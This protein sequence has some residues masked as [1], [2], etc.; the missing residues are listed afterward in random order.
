MSTSGVTT[1]AVQAYFCYQCNRTVTL[2]PSPD[3]DLSCPN[4]NGGFLE[5]FESS[6]FDPPNPNRNPSPFSSSSMAFPDPLSLFAD[7]FLSSSF[8]EG[9]GR[10]SMVLSSTT[11]GLGNPGNSTSLYGPSAATDYHE[12]PVGF[13]AIDFLQNYLQNLRASGANVQFV[14]ENHPP[15]AGFQLPA[16]LG[17]Y[18]LGPG[19]EQLI[20][21]LAENDPNRYGT[22]PASKRSVQGLP[23]VMITEAL[24]KSDS[25][26]CAVCMNEFGVGMEVKQ[27]PCSHLYH[28]DCLL[29]WLE[30]H[31]SCP[32]C[33]YELP[34]DDPDY[35]NRRGNRDQGSSVGGLGNGGDQGGSQGNP[36]AER[37]FRIS[38]PWPLSSFPFTGGNDDGGAG[39]TADSSSGAKWKSW[40][41]NEARKLGL[42]LEKV[43]KVIDPTFGVDQLFVPLKPFL[44][45]VVK[46]WD[47]W[48]TS[49][50]FF[51][52][53]FGLFPDPMFQ[54]ISCARQVFCSRGADVQFKFW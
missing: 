42:K 45:L 25:N 31:N 48:F 52:E 13:N 8:G 19:L 50:Y 53:M 12:S 3:S 36:T 34:T 20:Q 6:S 32:V 11:I 17:D 10:G 40:F 46:Q 54:A 21:Q 37:R 39:N 23:N 29:P 24:V 44:A 14:V 33:R 16:N 38:L 1:P 43:L 30:L 27:M 2:C 15:E 47:T 18:F 7:P 26:S 41:R 28:S 51:K 5:E 35:E 4:C 22:P 9:G 49:E